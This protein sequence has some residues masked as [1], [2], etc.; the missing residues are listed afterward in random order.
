MMEWTKQG[1]MMIPRT[2]EDEEEFAKLKNG[3]GFTVKRQN[4]TR[5]LKYHRRWFALLNVGFDHWEVSEDR[6]YEGRPIEKNFDRYRKDII[7]LAGFCTMVHRVDGTFTLESDSVSFAKMEENTFVELYS[8]TIDVLLKDILPKRAWLQFE[9][10]APQID[11]ATQKI[12]D[13]T[14]GMKR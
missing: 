2:E 14:I 6:Y 13:F 3:T 9:K 4:L 12:L 11:A 5:S 1:G 10:H 8:K 7:K